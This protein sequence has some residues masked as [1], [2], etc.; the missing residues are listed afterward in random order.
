MALTS[1]TPLLKKNGKV[2]PVAAG[3]SLRRL[4]GKGLARA[5][6]ADLAEQVG[7][8][9][10][11]VGTPGGAEALVHAAQ[12]E[13]G[14]DPRAVW[15]ALDLRNAFSSLSREAVLAAVEARPPALLPSARLFLGHRSRYRY[16]GGDGGEL[17]DADE[18]VDQG[19]PLAPAFLALTLR[20]PLARLEARLREAAEADGLTP[21]A[22]AD[23]VRVRAY[24]DDVLVRVPEGIAGRV[25]QE[26]ADALAGVGAALDPAKTQ[27]W[28]AEGGCPGGADLDAYWT[29]LGLVLL[30]APLGDEDELAGDS[31]PLGDTGF[32]TG[33]LRDK[34]A[35]Y[36]HFLG[37]VQTMVAQRRHASPVRRAGPSSCGSAASAGS[38]TSFGPYRPRRRRP[39]PNRPTRLRSLA[40][41]RW[42]AWTP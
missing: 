21:A 42:C 25:L 14:R 36:W 1:L 30:G 32:V 26:A 19:D 41:S 6:A 18:G 39:L 33:F 27:V 35:A 5:H 9:Q 23:A 20:D 2:R 24:L 29:P 17:L 37:A 10:F 31:A 8:T 11:G 40:T 13:A 3:E 7:G 16:L 38:L 15:V 12:V 22:A 4:A 34:F 28:R